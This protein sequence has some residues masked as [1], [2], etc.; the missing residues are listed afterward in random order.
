MW[1]VNKDNH[2]RLP[3]YLVG[4]IWGMVREMVVADQKDGWG[5]LM[6]EVREQRGEPINVVDRFIHNLE[7][8]MGYG[9][10]FESRVTVTIAGGSPEWWNYVVIVERESNKAE[11]FVES[12][13]GLNRQRG[14]VLVEIVRG[15]YDSH[16][17]DIQES[18]AEE[19]ILRLSRFPALSA[20]VWDSDFLNDVI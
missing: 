16:F 3:N 15:D 1:V 19:F 11:L 10:R 12:R 14:S 4:Y 2:I 5:D 9:C 17:V 8:G 13:E 20:C 7:G 18:E 6:E